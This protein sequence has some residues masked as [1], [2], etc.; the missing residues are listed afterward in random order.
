MLI[1]LI[2]TI[3]INTE[4]SKITIKKLNNLKQFASKNVNGL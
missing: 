4:T 2:H 3:S 1:F